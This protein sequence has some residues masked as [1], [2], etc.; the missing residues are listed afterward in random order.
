LPVFLPSNFLLNERLLENSWNVT[1]DS[2]AA[3]VAGKLHA[4]N[5]VL[6]TD[7]DGVFTCDPKKFSEAKLISSL[8]A[9]TLLKIKKRTSVDEFLP[10]LILQLKIRCYVVNGLYPDRVAAILDGQDTICTIIN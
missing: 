3:Y 9:E 5:V 7:V 1:S 8:S 2:I 4:N 10:K 6:V